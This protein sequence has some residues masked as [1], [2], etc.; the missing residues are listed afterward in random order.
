[1][2]LNIFRNNYWARRPIE[3]ELKKF[4]QEY[5][6]EGRLLDIGCGKKP[7]KNYFNNIKYIGLDSDKNSKADV[8]GNAWDLPFESDSF[9]V[10]LA[11]QS[12][13]HIEKLSESVEEI[14]RV[15]K[16]GGVAFI[17]V[18]HTM[19]N[20]SDPISSS[21]IDLN[22]FD[23]NEIKY[24]NNDFWRFTKFGLITLFNKFEILKVKETNG[25]FSTLFQMKNY[26][27]ASLPF[28]KLFFPIYFINNLNA[29]ICE[30]F[31]KGC[32][33]FARKIGFE[34]AVRFFDL[35]YWSLPLNYVVILRK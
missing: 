12:L 25:Y 31:F 24:W 13:E 16:K 28:N 20:H 15:L 29:L 23:K 7:Y 5:D 4:V 11:I 27:L 6:K 32:Y 21:D 14:S 35:V 2:P 22:N 18:P 19:R 8:I 3:K 33:F 10:V 1:M 9:D 26:F 30:L 34:K 17:S